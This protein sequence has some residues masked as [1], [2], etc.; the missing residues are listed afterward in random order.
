[1]SDIDIFLTKKDLFKLRVYLKKQEEVFYGKNLGDTYLAILEFITFKGSVSIVEIRHHHYFS[2][3]SISTVNRI[4]SNLK[5]DGS[6]KSIISEDDKRVIFLSL[7]DQISVICFK[8]IV[9]SSPFFL[10][11]LF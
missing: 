10:S 6:I 1:M 3:L 8:G 4:V 2:D 9:N 11:N 7:V 5:K